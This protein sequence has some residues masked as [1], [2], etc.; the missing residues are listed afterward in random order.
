MA[1]TNLI[2]SGVDT[3]NISWAGSNSSYPITN[4]VGT[5]ASNANK[6]GGLPLKTGSNAES[7]FYVLFD[8][9]SIPQDAIINTVTGQISIYET[10]TVT[11]RTSAR[12]SQLAS[13][14]TKKGNSTSFSHTSSATVSIDG[15]SD[16]TRDE[17][18]DLRI[19]S[20]WKRNTSNTT[21]TTTA[22]W[23]GADV[24]IEYTEDSG[25]KHKVT[26]T[27]KDVVVDEYSAEIQEKKDYTIYIRKGSVNDITDNGKDVLDKIV[28]KKDS[29]ESVDAISYPTSYTISSG[30]VNGTKYQNAIGQSSSNTATGNDYSSSSG[31]TATIM[32][33]FDFSSIPDVATIESVS[34]VVGGHLESTSSSSEKAELQ[35]YSGSTK[36]GTSSSFSS[37]SKELITM[38]AGL[39][40]REE[41]QNAKLAFTIGYY[42]GLVNGVDF[43]VKYSIAG[44][45]DKYYIYTIYSITED[46]VVLINVGGDK[47]TPLRLKVDGTYKKIKKIFRKENG[48]YV[49]KAIDDIPKNNI[50]LIQ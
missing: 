42:G 16:W 39:W 25:K 41:L 20:Y 27:A 31:S 37:T 17:I 6:Y 19:Y 24:T 12:Y 3:S 36:K 26:I 34:V 21:S 9:S 13:G 30:S 35:L 47:A 38:D 44:G 29:G 15:G 1:S 45:G 22:Y 43:K 48:V 40:T 32:Y 11:S 28:E 18:S 49:E 7:Y 33:S 50:R 10:S 4:P 23:R 8:T 14:T 2:C 46:H 5:S